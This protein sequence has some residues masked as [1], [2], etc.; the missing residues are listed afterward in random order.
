MKIQEIIKMW[1]KKLL[2]PRE[3]MYKDKYQWVQ[4]RRKK[5]IYVWIQEAVNEEN[6]IK[7]FETLTHRISNTTIILFKQYLIKLKLFMSDSHLK[8]IPKVEFLGNF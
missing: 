4:I 7:H 8:S 3:R 6:K 5:Q 1:H 2:L